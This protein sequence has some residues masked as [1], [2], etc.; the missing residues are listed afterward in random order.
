MNKEELLE[1]I[2]VKTPSKII[3]IVLDGLG[4]LPYKDGKTELEYAKKSNLNALTGKSALGLAHPILR[5]ITPGSGPAHIALFGYNP[6]KYIVGRGLLE[7][8]GLGVETKKGDMAI[9]GNFCTLKDGLVSDRRAGR[10]PTDKSIELCK[11]LNKNV[12][13]I[14]GVDVLFTPGMEHRF[15]LRLRGKGLSDKI[16]ET[17]PQKVGERPVIPEALEKE[18]EKTSQVLK[19]IT[20]IAKDTLK[21]EERAN[22]VL[23]RGYSLYPPIPSMNELFKLTPAAIATYPMYKG[24]AKLV[25]MDVL[26]VNGMTIA[27]E[28]KTLKQNYKDYDFF[29]FHVKKT[30]SYGEDG[31]FDKKISIIEE[32]DK[33][34]P[35]ILSLSFDVVV[36]TSDHSTPC[37]LKGHSWHPNPFLIYS[38]YVIADEQ[39]EFSEKSCAKGILGHFYAKDAMSLML[40]NALKLNK[41]GA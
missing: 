3:L 35:E 26:K 27:D 10:I 19:K 24:L 39:D 40:A 37:L 7:N 32:F 30:D 2:S 22:F 38:K 5:G 36:I 41:F 33:V 15:A 1:E 16:K 12:G 21:N 28:L 6:L 4:G 25:G 14:D 31:N 11:K 34:L 8:L 17:D 29:Y 18:G 13:K 20:R 23:L 9:R